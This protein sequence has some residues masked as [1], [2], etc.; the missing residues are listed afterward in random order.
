MSYDL[1]GQ[2]DRAKRASA[3]TG[4]TRAANTGDRES[5][6]T[7]SGEV[8]TIRDDTHRASTDDPLDLGIRQ[9]TRNPSPISPRTHLQEWAQSTDKDKPPVF[10]T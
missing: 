5:L 7:E 9:R 6:D 8:N 1:F 2:T 4:E 10:L 3:Y